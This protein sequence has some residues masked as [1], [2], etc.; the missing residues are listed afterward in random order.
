MAIMFPSKLPREVMEDPKRAAEIQVYKNFA[1]QLD[2]KYHVFYSSPWLGILPDGSEV[3]GEAD[4][5]VAHPDKGILVVEVKGG[6]VEIDTNGNWTSTDRYNI[7]RNIKNPVSQARTSKHILLNKLKGSS[8]WL[9]RF[10]CARHGVILPHVTKPHQDFRLDMPLKIFAFDDDMNHLHAWVEARLGSNEEREDGPAEPLGVDGLY[11]L[12]DMIARHIKLRVRLGTTVTQDLQNI[13]LKTEEQIWILKDTEEN[14]RMAISGA[15]GTGKTIL[16]IEK[17]IMLAEEGKST[18]LLCFNRALS[19]NL[20]ASVKGYSLITATHFHQ[21]C[22][23]IAMKAG[24][25]MSCQNSNMLAADL[26]DNFAESGQEEF[27]ALIIDEGQDFHNDWLTDLKV[28]VK[29][30]DQG[31]LYIFYDDNQ[32]VMFSATTY[33]KR[34]PLAKYHLSRNFRNTQA[35][36]KQA[37]HHYVG[38]FVRAIGPEGRDPVWHSVSNYVDL[39]A[40]LA[41]RFE[42]LVETEGLQPSDIAILCPDTES[43]NLFADNGSL[44]LGHYSAVD[45]E[46]R[47]ANKLVI[48]TIRRFKGLESPVVFL[49]LN[50]SISGNKELLYTG[51]TRAQAVMEVFA[52]KHVIHLLHNS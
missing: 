32:N 36:F 29:D 27:D 21:F 39:K 47:C 17:A 43:V 15:A 34:L 19:K 24:V 30:G 35:I 31:I 22:H 4:F 33:I 48:G 38:G 37:D 14:K 7:T 16:A 40:R 44:R 13:Q 18:L 10:I 6:R 2:N 49:I 26:V 28:V 45:A 42:C 11:A 3:D 9:P 46:N 12:D 5:L 8:R 25:N 23:D 41:E 50:S 52:P 20:Q 51:I 1:E